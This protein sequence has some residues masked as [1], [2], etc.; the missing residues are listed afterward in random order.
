MASLATPWQVHT[1][2]CA[3]R[4]E[5]VGTDPHWPPRV[6]HAGQHKAGKSLAPKRL[7][8]S[9]GFQARV[10]AVQIGEGALPVRH[11]FSDDGSPRAETT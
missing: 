7:K 3:I 6:A 1:E 5:P 9:A 11:S 10:R 2:N 8:D 4:S